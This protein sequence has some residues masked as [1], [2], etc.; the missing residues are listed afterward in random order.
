MSSSLTATVVA[1]SL[2]VLVAILGARFDHLKRSYY[3]G[4]SIW[5]RWLPVLATAIY[6]SLLVV[7]L[8]NSPSQV[9]STLKLTSVFSTAELTIL[10]LVGPLFMTKIGFLVAFATLSFTIERFIS[11]GIPTSSAG[12]MYLFTSAVTFVAL[13]G[14][15]MPWFANQFANPVA[16]KIRDIMVV[17]VAVGSLGVIGASFTQVPHFQKWVYQ[18][19]SIDIPKFL[20]LLVLIAVFIGWLSVVLGFTRNVTIPLMSLP[21]LFIL[22][23]ITHWPSYLLIIPFS[24]CLA[25]ALSTADRRSN[26][27]QRTIAGATVY[28][29]R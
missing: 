28:M 6:L 22:A 12:C 29:S 8:V 14:D 7:N 20:L 18:V 24:I 4:V 10:F 19:L 21:T 27:R 11:S 3:F 23:F 1:A 25:L 26:G 17:G 13:L 5:S 9:P 2:I 16:Q 15:K